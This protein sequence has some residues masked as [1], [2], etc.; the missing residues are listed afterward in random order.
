MDTLEIFFFSPLFTPYS[1]IWLLLFSLNSI[2]SPPFPNPHLLV[3]GICLLPVI[4]S[5]PP[6]IPLCSLTGNFRILAELLGCRIAQRWGLWWSEMWYWAF[7][8]LFAACWFVIG[9]RP[10][11]ESVHS[12]QLWFCCY[13]VVMC[14]DCFGR[15]Y[16]SRVLPTLWWSPCSAWQGWLTANRASSWGSGVCSWKPVAVNPGV[17][18]HLLWPWIIC[19]IIQ[20]ISVSFR[21]CFDF[22]RVFLVGRLCANAPFNRRDDSMDFSAT[23]GHLDVSLLTS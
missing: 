10:L 13:R 5:L 14:P 16:L 6:R 4:P 21:G 7:S 22:W 15:T 19:I 1:H 11:H 17:P 2:F 23:W 3:W 12:L 18:L 8:P 20:K 9:V